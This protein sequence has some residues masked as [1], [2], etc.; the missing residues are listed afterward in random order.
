MCDTL[1][2]LTGDGVLF[3]K[4]SDRDPNE[5]QVLRWYA[6]EDHADARLRCTWSEIDQVPHTHAVLLSQPWWMWGAEMGANEHG[7]V[8]GNEAVFTRGT[9][10]Q[11]S[12][13]ALLGMDLVRLGLER[14]A[15]A[16]E[17]VEVIV[18]LLERHGQG[19]SC[20][21]EHPRFTY[22]NS[23]IVAD[24]GGAIVLET[25]GRRW[26]TE[27]VTGRG[28]SISNGLT[29]P[30]FAKAHA[31]PLRGRVAQC[32]ARRSR[33]QAAAERADEVSAMWAALRDHGGPAPQWSRVNGALS[34]PCAHAAGL[35]TTT[36]STASW[37]ADLRV[38]PRHWVT[39][40]SA[41]CTSI[42]KPVAVDEPVTTDPAAMPTNR[43]DA[44]YR[45]WR[46]ER[47]HR[48]ALRDHPSAL[49]RFGGERDRVEQEWFHDPPPS[50]EAFRVADHL[51]E[52]W[53]EDL[54]QARLDETRPRWLR[55]RWRA[56]DRAAGMPVAL[57]MSAS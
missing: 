41:P 55:R 1:V 20:S 47:L 13:S 10:R 21:H 16:E 11:R 5:A 4:N 25:A 37:V 3:A 6:A 51:E 23:F 22:D 35:L 17:A 29:I 45:W 52:S 30:D 2:S 14:S 54:G 38:D 27:Q 43:Y 15:T 31:D 26:A 36:Q 7:V 48:L 53:L 46:H 24:Q 50:A 28:R 18:G 34:A 40:T 42:A 39:G 8:I 33:T 12:D 57:G 49:A 9:G 19:G 32:A 56:I 44:A